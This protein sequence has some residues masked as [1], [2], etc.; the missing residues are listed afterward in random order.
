MADDRIEGMKP[1]SGGDEGWS[2]AD[3]GRAL[4]EFS[5]TSALPIA[6]GLALGIPASLTGIPGL[7]HAAGA[8]GVAG[9]EILNQ[10]LGITEQDPWAV[11]LSALPI[12]GAG[13]GR[14]AALSMEGAKAGL[15]DVVNQKLGLRGVNLMLAVR[16]SVHSSDLFARVSQAGQPVKVGLTNTTDALKRAKDE[17]AKYPSTAAELNQI[18]DA[19]NDITKGGVTHVDFNKMRAVQAWSGQKVADLARSKHRI[20]KGIANQLYGAMWDDVNAAAALTPG[21]LGTLLRDAVAS[22][23]REEA[24]DVIKKAF[25][26]AVEGSQEVV[27]VKQAWKN[28]ATNEEKLVKLIGRAEYDDIIDT[29]K[30]SAKLLDKPGKGP[31]G[32][33]TR[34]PYVTAGMAAG[35]LGGGAALGSSALMLGGATAMG[36]EGM[37]LFLMSAPGRSLVRQMAQHGVAFDQLMNFAGQAVLSGTLR[38]SPVSGAVPL[39]MLPQGGP[40]EVQLQTPMRVP[41]R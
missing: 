14:A 7:G 37:S 19:L 3:L 18:V 9:G 32:M 25:K 21:T 13:T 40:S 20:E 5:K 12:M 11:A 41:L 2:A 24:V 27:N 1:L 30:D 34:H 4:V 38:Q 33:I 28:I 17:M 26:P 29:L 23:K 35:G 6:G 10:Q 16:P 22:R 31:I 15:R 36:L 39:G 8:L